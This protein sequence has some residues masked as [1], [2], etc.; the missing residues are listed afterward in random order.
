MIN[1]YNKIVKSKKEEIELDKKSKSVEALMDSKYFHRDKKSF[2]YAIKHT[3]N[4]KILEFNR[5]SPFVDNLNLDLKIDEIIPIYQKL[6]PI[7]ISIY[8]DNFFFGGSLK[9]LKQAKKYGLPLLAKDFIL[10]PYQIF[11]AKSAGADMIVLIPAILDKIQLMDLIEIADAVG[12]EILL[13]FHVGDNL[14]KIPQKVDLVS[15]NNRDIN[16]SKIDL[17]KALEIKNC[18]STEIPCISSGGISIEAY[19][20]LSNDFDAFLLENCSDKINDIENLFH[21]S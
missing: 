12:L 11:Q 19:S 1:I 6:N 2:K 13:E 14:F 7:G 8:T 4:G 17:K 15:I 21:Q 10:D 20:Y 16:T 9:D 3:K 5:K 18:L